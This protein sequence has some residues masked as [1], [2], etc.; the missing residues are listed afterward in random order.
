MA[1]LLR[2]FK[3]PVFGAFLNSPALGLEGL[4][5]G[6]GNGCASQKYILFEI[7]DFFA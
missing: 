5:G 6:R 7:I 3:K 2:S 1:L 4:A